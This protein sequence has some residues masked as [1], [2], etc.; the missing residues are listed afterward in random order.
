MTHRMCVT[1][2][3]EKII[4]QKAQRVQVMYVEST[5]ETHGTPIFLNENYKDQS[6]L[7]N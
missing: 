2:F 6:T 3:N 5:H 4:N 1:F 7:V